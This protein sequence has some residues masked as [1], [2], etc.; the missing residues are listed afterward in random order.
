MPL[1][2]GLYLHGGERHFGGGAHSLKALVGSEVAVTAWHPGR[3][4]GAMCRY[5][6]PRHDDGGVATSGLYGDENLFGL[7]VDF[8][9]LEI[10]LG[11]LEVGIF[12]G[13]DLF[14]EGAPE[15]FNVGWRNVEVAHAFCREIGVHPRHLHIGDRIHR[16]VTLELRHGGVN[17][18]RQDG[19]TGRW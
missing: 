17:V 16:L 10:N 3:R 19:E 5:S 2:T 15:L 8:H 18:R 14:S 13:A 4:I 6:L 1:S 11:E 9:R 12:G 7:V